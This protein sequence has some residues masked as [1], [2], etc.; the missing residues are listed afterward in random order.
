MRYGRLIAAFLFIATG[1]VSGGVSSAATISVS[2]KVYLQAVVRPTQYIIVNKAN[3]IIE[4]G[5]NTTQ[6]V[7]PTVYL[8]K[9]SGSSKLPLN[10]DV[11]HSYV[12]LTSGI[13]LRA[14][15]LY[16]KTWSSDDNQSPRNPSLSFVTIR[17]FKI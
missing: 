12:Q 4:I 15:V 8:N 5:S 9:V 6:A 2:Q 11:Y 17:S 1:L 3:Q 13:N 16:K 14:G 10:D 7:R